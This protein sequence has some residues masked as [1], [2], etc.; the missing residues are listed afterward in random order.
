MGRIILSH[1][2]LLSSICSSFLASTQL[3]KERKY[4]FMG[5]LNPNSGTASNP[6]QSIDTDIIG[7]RF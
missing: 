4:W 3:L 6:R 2:V 5:I 1:T 7:Q